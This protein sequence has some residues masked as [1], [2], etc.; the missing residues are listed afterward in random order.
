M[1]KRSLGTATQNTV[2]CPISVKHIRVIFS[3]LLG[4]H[5]FVVL[6]FARVAQN[7]YESS[8][9]WWAGAGKSEG[10]RRV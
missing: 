3:G 7:K 10:F 4:A 1:F 9:N 6:D 5:R 8:Y 2:C